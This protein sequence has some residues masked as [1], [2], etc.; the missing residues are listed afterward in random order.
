MMIIIIFYDENMYV[1]IIQHQ[2]TIFPRIYI[3][4]IHIKEEI[5]H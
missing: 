2:M 5:H 4:E 3:E 1:N